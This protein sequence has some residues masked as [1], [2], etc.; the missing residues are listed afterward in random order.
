MMIS[1][2]EY[3]KE[4][5]E[6]K[7]AAQLLKVIRGLKNEMGHLK[8]LMEDPNCFKETVTSPD[9]SVRLACTRLYL[10]RAKEAL[11]E[12]GWVYTPSQAELR[13]M[14]FE[15]N[16]P[17]ICKM[18]LSLGDYETRTFILT[19]EGL[20]L[21]TAATPFAQATNSSVTLACPYTKWE[22]L[23][24]LRELKLG[25]WRRSYR[26]SRFGLMVMDGTRWELEIRFANGHRPFRACGYN[27]YPYNFDKLV[28]LFGMEED[29]YG[30]DC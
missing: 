12:T 2:E 3:Y 1:P 28:E 18:S 4:K 9:E 8:R 6:G 20:Q 17:A 13:S 23:A 10:Q 15:E 30:E 21:Q 11:A 19:K 27:A 25:E 16:I 24:D 7:N 22:L 14:E 26:L 5:L 29:E